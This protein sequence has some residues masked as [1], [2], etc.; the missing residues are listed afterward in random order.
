MTLKEKLLK[1]GYFIDNEYLANYIKLVENYITDKLY[2]ERHHILQRAYF[3]LN[4]L[5]VDNSKTNI[6]KLAYAD[7]CKAH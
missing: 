6:V 2:T 3:E 1:T 5:E 4:G 7:H